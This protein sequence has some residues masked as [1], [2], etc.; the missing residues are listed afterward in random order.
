MARSVG[1]LALIIVVAVGGYLYTKQAQTIAPEGTGPQTTIDVTA[2]RSDL[3]TLAN[4]ERQFYASNG[5][6]VSLDEL[7][8]AGGVNLPRRPNYSYSAEP[9]DT[10]FKITASYSGSDPKAPKNIVINETMSI[11]TE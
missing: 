7:N 11:T 3:M 5:K 9:G 1:L 10:G 4:A 6:Y 8:S 2:V